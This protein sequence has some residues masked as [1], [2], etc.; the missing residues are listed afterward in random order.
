MNHEL[1][2]RILRL[3]ADL[4]SLQDLTDN[5][6]CALQSYLQNARFIIFEADS[7]VSPLPRDLYPQIRI[8]GALQRLAYHDPD[9]GGETYIANWC[10]R[11]W[12][13]LLQ[14][15]PNNV[16][17]LQGMAKAPQTTDSTGSC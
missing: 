5:N 6:A 16:H 9:S 3:E 4:E 14:N 11:K 12:V 17:V 10:E 2:D 15:N 13:A 8:L 1:N 7:G